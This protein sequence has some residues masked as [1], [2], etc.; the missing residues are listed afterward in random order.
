MPW[1][2]DFE[3]TTKASD[4]RVWA[5]AICN[6]NNPTELLFGNSIVSF[7]DLISKSDDTYYFH[8][9]KFDGG[10]LVDWL[11]RNG[12]EHV[13]GKIIGEGKFGTLIS[14]M[15]AWYTISIH[16][17]SGAQVK[18]IDSLKLITMP[19]S[20]MPKTFG[21]EETK[22]EIDYN[23]EREIGHELTQDEKDYIAHDVIILAKALS[24]MFS[25]GMNKLTTA[26]NALADFR[27]RY[28][29][30]E[31]ERDF[32]DKTINVLSD[33]FIRRSYKGGFT[34]L[35]PKWKNKSVEAGRVYDVN[36]MYPWA[37]KYC[38]L[39]YG[40]ARWYRGKY[41]PDGMYPLYV[42]ALECE[43]TLK[44]GMVPTL[45]IKHSMY[46]ENEYLI[47]SA[48]PTYLCLTSV[49]LQLF[50]DHYD[51]EVHEWIEGY[52][53]QAKVG[54]FS[55]YIDH[56]YGVKTQAKIDHNSGMA[57]IAKLML[58]SLYG[59][60]GS[61]RNGRSK[62]PYLDD[63]K[64]KVCFKLTEDEE[65]R[66]GYLPIATFITSYC[67]DKIIRA[68]QTCGKR[69]IYADTDSLHIEGTEDVPGLDVDEYRLGAFKLEEEFVRAKFIRQKTYMEIYNS[70][71]GEE[72]NI[73]CAGMPDN[74]KRT[75]LE[76]DFYEGATFTGKLMPTVVPGGVILKETT[77][78]IKKT[79]SKMERNELYDTMQRNLN[80]T[81]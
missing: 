34:Y 41:E 47:E 59:K 71:K 66:G 29:P 77:F 22:L 79:G 36:S 53:F 10:F 38:L 30:K 58:N 80:T 25:N 27:K 72:M 39:P 20:A 44:P 35:N 11:L 69:F 52:C 70:E 48:G 78:Q 14:D 12:F 76:Q 21:I 7:F 64:D 55:E 74:I 61:R 50:F 2:S 49:D 75:L 51:V 42:Q 9:L 65:R 28:G 62:I 43:F 37:M 4:C 15:G 63:E 81:V 16:F 46:A 32:G 45:Q 24:F 60:F 5:W 6:I 40:S 68:A 23:E 26:S 19:I 57:Q 54:I 1:A 67:R 18:I 33:R 8:N 73:K 56:W 13:T 31:Y 17:P 3:T